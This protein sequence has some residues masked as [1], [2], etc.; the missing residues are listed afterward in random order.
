[1]SHRILKQTVHTAGTKVSIFVCRFALVYLLAHV[2]TPEDYGAYSIISILN[3]FGVMLVGLNLYNYLYRKA[4]GQRL[5]RRVVLFKSTFLFEVLLSGILVAVFLASG[6]LKPVMGL[7]KASDYAP[8]FEV[9]L[10]L[11]VALVAASEVQHYLLAKTQI[12]RTNWMELITQ[13]GWIPF[14]LALWLFR[15]KLTVAG[16]LLAQL[17][18]VLVGTAF[19]FG[20]VE[21]SEWW[22]ARPDSRVIRAALAFS[23]PMIIPGLSFYVLKLADRFVLSHYRSLWEVGLYSFA[24]SFLNTLYAFSALVILNTL[25]PYAVEAHNR[26]ETERRNFLLTYAL[27]SSLMVFGTGVAF[28]LAFSRPILTLMARRD[29]LAAS[30]VLPLLAVSF[31]MIIIAYPAHYLLMLE[32]RTALL[33]GIDLSGIAI[34]LTLDLLLIPRYSYLGAAIASAVGFGAVALAKIVCGRAWRHIQFHE[35]FGWRHEFSVVS[36]YLRSQ[37]ERSQPEAIP[38]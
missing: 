37:E 21:I 19:A 23:V 28:L 6:A 36:Q 1:M 5:E 32:T 7:L 31:V 4:P 22:H 33:M 13:A 18:A 20:R 17:L 15:L 35:F 11:L 29:Y 14:L 27:K 2:F 10:I 12:E 30:E 34:G 24:Y 16:V 8:A 26:E 25:L 38:E 9:G 3:T